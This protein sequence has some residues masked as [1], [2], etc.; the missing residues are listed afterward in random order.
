[1]KMIS[2]LRKA[3]AIVDREIATETAVNVK[4][5]RVLQIAMEDCLISLIWNAEKPYGL[6]SVV[7][8]WEKKGCGS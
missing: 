6:R 7:S 2:P 5:N 4:G 3:L 8:V 1:M